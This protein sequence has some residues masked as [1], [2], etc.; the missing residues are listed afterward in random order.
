MLNAYEFN[1]AIDVADG[2]ILWGC[3][4]KYRNSE[5]LT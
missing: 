2:V 1:S 4:D 5:Y 3:S